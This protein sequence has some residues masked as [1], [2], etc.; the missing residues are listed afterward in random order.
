MVP[1]TTETTVVFVAIV[2]T[3]A[4]LLVAAVRVAAPASEPAAA[5]TRWTWSTALGIG[6]FMA[7]TGLVSGSGVLQPSATPPRVM[8]FFGGS[9]LTVVAAALSPLGTRLVAGAP[10]LGLVGFQ[11]FRLPLELVLHRWW[12]QGVLPVQ[13]TYSGHNFD[14]V[15]GVAAM[16]AAAWIWR[17]GPSRVVIAAFNVLGF[18]LLVTVASIA[19]RSTPGPRQTYEQGPPVLLAFH[20]PFGWIVPMCV[21]GALFGHVLVFRWLWARR[22]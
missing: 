13:M 9:M 22:G 3:L 18:A 20:F 17:R 4:A 6:A 10:I 11:A 16:V 19:I 21:G 15:T 7:L 5:T 2:V 12:Q 14:I 1:P 8:F